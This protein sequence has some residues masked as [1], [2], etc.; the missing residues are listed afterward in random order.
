MTSV[1]AANPRVRDLVTKI[2][3]FRELVTVI[4]SGTKNE[5]ENFG[6]SVDIEFDWLQAAT[7]SPVTTSVASTNKAVDNLHCKFSVAPSSV[8]A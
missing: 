4:G 6:H 5:G 3:K 2:D 8:P 1:N 7:F